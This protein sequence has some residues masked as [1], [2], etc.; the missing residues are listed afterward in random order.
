[1][2][3]VNMQVVNCTTSAQFFHLLRRQMRRSFRKPLIV[4]SPKKLLKSKDANSNIEDFDEGLR[5]KRII[6]D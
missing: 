6:A 4:A 3:R 1:M 5:F 2:E